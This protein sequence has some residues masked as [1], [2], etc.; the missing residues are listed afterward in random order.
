[1]TSAVTE[2]CPSDTDWRIFAWN[3]VQQTN[4]READVRISVLTTGIDDVKLK[5]VRDSAHS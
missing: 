2:N 4:C 3:A 1:M 5:N